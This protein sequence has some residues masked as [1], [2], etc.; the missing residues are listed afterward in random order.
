MSSSYDLREF[1]ERIEKL[2]LLRKV[3]GASWDLE[4]GA[5]TDANA[6]RNKYTLL[7]DKIPGYPEG[8]RVLTGALL[9]SRRVSTALDL[10][11]NLNN[12]ELT[13][14]IREKL[15]NVE[16]GY[17]KYAPVMVD[18][19]PTMENVDK[20][21]RIDFFKFPVPKW[22]HND[23]GRYIGTADA[24]ITRDPESGWVNV[25]TYRVMVKDSKR[26]AILMEASRHGR[27]HVEKNLDSGKPAPIALSFG[28]NPGLNLFSSN[29]VPEGMSEYN[30]LGAVREK[31]VHTFK[32]PVTG[33]P[34]PADSEIAVEGYIT[35]ERTDEGPLGEFMGYY[36]GGKMSNP[37]IKIEAV[38]YRNRP[39]LMGTCAGKP[40]Y[41]YS[42][43]RCPI[44]ASLIW[45]ALEGSGVAGVKG[46]WC[47]EEGYSR[48]FTAVSVKQMFGGHAVMAGHIASQSRPGNVAGR[49]TVVVD[50][51][52]DPSNLNEVV[53]A[54]CSRND[55]ASGI[56]I[57]RN[58]MGTPLD[59]I[60]KHEE[61]KDLLE[62]TASRAI[63]M[64]VKPFE[65]IMKKTF[66]DV[67]KADPDTD[68]KVHDKWPDLFKKS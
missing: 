58:T 25:G 4:I 6:K 60:A 11:S 5:I 43:Y 33:L 1:I 31:P 54:M 14:A 27:S 19:P 65:K 15:R 35:G 63:V 28:H 17:E 42:Y 64:A 49:Y 50:D 57:V 62:Y 2:G 8:F 9:D 13:T 40:P 47:H 20:G 23:G 29:E 12:L 24:V 46:V 38:Y 59:P 55:P 21:D 26:L 3:E 56:D 10:D 30:F 67:V 36:A 16:K 52:I 41:D 68:R 7:F 44:R 51:D 39:I 34:I 53:W 48:A 32:G 61:G 18:N 66:P 45:N 22:F 37:V